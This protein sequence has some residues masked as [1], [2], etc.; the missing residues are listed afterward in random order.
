MSDPSID[1]TLADSQ[2]SGRSLS[3]RAVLAEIEASRGRLGRV[4]RNDVIASSPMAKAWADKLADTETLVDLLGRPMDP[5]IVDTVVVLRLLRIPT[6][7]SCWGHS[8]RA[9]NGPWVDVA[10]LPGDDYLPLRRRVDGFLGV[11]YEGRRVAPYRQLAAFDL[12]TEGIEGPTTVRIEAR[13][14]REVRHAERPRTTADLR[15]ARREFVAF[16][17]AL[18]HRLIASS[19]TNRPDR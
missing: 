14:S 6:C 1:P 18:I 19:T 8:H 2:R 4:D 17:D 15:S 9:A 10:P 5:G 12:G 7:G 11:F 3:S 16:T 13:S